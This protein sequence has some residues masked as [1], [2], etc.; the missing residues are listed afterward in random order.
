MPCAMA[1]PAHSRSSP[2]AMHRD[3]EGM[4][5]S[6]ILVH[7]TVNVDGLG[8]PVLRVYGYATFQ[9]RSAPSQFRCPTR[10]IPQ[11]SL[12]FTHDLGPLLLKATQFERPP[13]FALNS[14][15]IARTI[16]H[17][18]MTPKMGEIFDN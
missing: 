14:L 12:L 11:A 10:P 18:T 9:G 1:E 13:N 17:R 15:A 4:A 3:R 5:I 2:I 7:R 8:Q 16:V 6:G